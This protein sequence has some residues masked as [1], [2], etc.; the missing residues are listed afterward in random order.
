M[1]QYLFSVKSEVNQDEY[2]TSENEEGTIICTDV[3]MGGILK[4]VHAD[5]ADW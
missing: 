3:E 2:R 1:H 5:G 4:P